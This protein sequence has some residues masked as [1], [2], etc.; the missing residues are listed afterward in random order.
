MK[1]ETCKS[2]N[3]IGETVCTRC[4]GKGRIGGFLGLGSGL[5]DACMGTGKGTCVVCLGE[6]ELVFEPFLAVGLRSSSGSRSGFGGFSPSDSPA[7]ALS[8]SGP[9]DPSFDPFPPVAK[10]QAPWQRRTAVSAELIPPTW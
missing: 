7:G 6:G 4:Q 9:C 2:C 10:P 8:R 1:R 3:G 5:C